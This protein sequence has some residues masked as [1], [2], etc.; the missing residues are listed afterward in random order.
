MAGAAGDNDRLGDHQFPVDRHPQ[1]IFAEINRLN[2]AELDSRAKFLRLFLQPG[3]QFIAIHA[4]RKSRIILDDA[5]G[6]EQSA[7]HDAREDERVQISP[8]RVDSRGQSRATTSDD[9]DVFHSGNIIINNSRDARSGGAKKRKAGVSKRGFLTPRSGFAHFESGQDAEH[10]AEAADRRSRHQSAVA[11]SQHHLVGARG[12]YQG[13]KSVV[14]APDGSFLSVHC[15][16]PGG[17]VGLGHHQQRR[18]IRRDLGFN[19]LR[20]ETRGRQ[21]CFRRPEAAGRRFGLRG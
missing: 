14:G 19:A 16:L 3:H 11:I 21:L 5:R 6:G 9:D 8:G 2:I 17:V 20:A 13:L 15:G 7:G 1:G 10:Q 4:V 12:D 18:S